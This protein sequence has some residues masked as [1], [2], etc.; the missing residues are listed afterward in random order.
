VAA[1]ENL[2]VRIELDT[3]RLAAEFAGSVGAERVRRCVSAARSRFADRGPDAFLPA[4]VTNHARRLLQ[5]E[6]T[7]ARAS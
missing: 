6:M 5:E 2:D 3:R 1:V 4:L 7:D